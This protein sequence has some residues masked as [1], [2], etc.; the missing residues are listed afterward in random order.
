MFSIMLGGLIG[1]AITG[2]FFLISVTPSGMS[3]VLA[4]GW[5]L[6]DRNAVG[7]LFLLMIVLLTATDGLTFLRVGGTNQS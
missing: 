2:V 1:L 3:G 7:N 5:S 4:V 6:L